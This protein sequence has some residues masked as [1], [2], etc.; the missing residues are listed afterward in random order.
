[1]ASLVYIK[2]I[3]PDTFLHFSY[4]QYTHKS[5]ESWKLRDYTHDVSPILSQGTSDYSAD[6]IRI[7]AKRPGNHYLVNVPYHSI[8]DKEFWQ[9]EIEK[10]NRIYC[11][12]QSEDNS[13]Q[14]EGQLNLFVSQQEKE[15]LL[16]FRK[17]S[18]PKQATVVNLV[19]TLLTP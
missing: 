7:M 16:S 9:E 15:L 2:E 14:K 17:L 3:R 8:T 11:V 6:E 5:E 19:E 10:Q 1:M 12:E 13:F 18:I 4:K